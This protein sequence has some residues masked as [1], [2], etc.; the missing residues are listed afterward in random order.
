MATRTPPLE[1]FY[2]PADLDPAAPRLYVLRNG[3]GWELRDEEGTVLT[4]H[5]TQR[6]AIDA[7]LAR[8]AVAFCEILVRGST[9]EAEWRVGQ[10]ART[11]ELSGLL[12]RQR[13]E[14][15]GRKVGV[16][17]FWGHHVFLP[18]RYKCKDS[19]AAGV[20][21]ELYYDP[22]E[23]DPD[24]PRLRIQKR[25]G[26][27]ELRDDEGGLLSSHSALPGALDAA[28]NRSRLRFSEILVRSSSGRREWSYNHNPEWMDLARI[29][30]Q[31]VASQRE[32]AD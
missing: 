6:D 11:R 4:T 30:N 32:A 19:R 31:A 25:D 23:L 1:R 24:A 5:P 2:D 14:E 28:L 10:D 3:A 9:E 16:G 26:R 8:S 7:G 13:R 20:A 29:L 18:V 17:P 27:W 12:P 15:R 21:V 22:A